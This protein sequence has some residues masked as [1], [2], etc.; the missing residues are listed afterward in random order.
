[1]LLALDMI[2][3]DDSQGLERA[4][5][6]ARPVVDEVV[7]GVDARTTDPHTRDVARKLADTVWEFDHEDLGVSEAEWKADRMHF[8]RARNLC[9]ARVRAQWT[10][11]L[12]SDEYLVVSNS[13][14]VREILANAGAHGMHAAGIEVDFEG[15]TFVDFQRI[16]LTRL[17][18]KSAMHEQLV[19]ATKAVSVD[20]LMV[21]RDSSYRTESDHERRARQREMGIADLRLK[22]DEGHIFAVWHVA[23]HDIGNA[24]AAAAEAAV[25]R[26][27]EHKQS[28]A[29][30][31]AI[32]CVAMADRYCCANDFLRAKMWAVRGLLDGPSKSAFMMLAEIAE[33]ESDSEGVRIWG[34]GA[35]MTPAR[36]MERTG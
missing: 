5:N 14:D 4:I 6:S 9:R 34:V 33:M 19:G 36:T 12:D 10:L 16:A 22:A 20:G 31:R 2:V 27:M 17:Q 32:L 29:D 21:C 35:E 23:K 24:D 1:M 28:T 18:W 3:R 30:Q 26:Y 13:A 7:V 25:S 8:A 11:F 15:F